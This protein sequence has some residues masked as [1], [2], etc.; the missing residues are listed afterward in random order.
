MPQDHHN[1]TADHGPVDP[2]NRWATEHY[3]FDDD[4]REPVSTRAASVSSTA[5]GRFPRKRMLLVAGVLGLALT[6]GVGGAA[7]AA[8]SNGGGGTGNGAGRGDN[9]HL[10]GDRDGGRDGGFR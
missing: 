6:A 5:E 1:A 9:G 4:A 10:D 2:V 3:G 8:D 7:L